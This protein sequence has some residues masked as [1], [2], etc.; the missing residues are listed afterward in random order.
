MAYSPCHSIS[1]TFLLPLASLSDHN[2]SPTSRTR[3][4]NNNPPL[5]PT[6]TLPKTN[7]NNNKMKKQQR[8]PQPSVREVERVIG[9]GCYRDNDP[10]PKESE[11]DSE[12][13]ESLFDGI[14]P[15]STGKFEGPVEKKLRKTGEWLAVQTESTFQ[16]SGRRILI[17]VLWWVLPIWTLLLLVASGAIELPFSTPLLDDLLM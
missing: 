8:P 14:L 15:I 16:S 7:N 6:S 9:A 12:E 2:P 1:T 5:I 10:N 11:E 17:F 3:T 4:T 13:L